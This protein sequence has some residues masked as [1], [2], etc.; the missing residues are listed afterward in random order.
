MNTVERI[1]LH[2]RRPTTDRLFKL[3]PATKPPLLMSPD[4]IDTSTGLSYGALQHDWVLANETAR[5]L[6]AIFQ[7]ETDNYAAGAAI[8]Q[9]ASATNGGLVGAL[10]I[11]LGLNR[12]IFPS[13][14]SQALNICAGIASAL[15]FLPRTPTDVELVE[16]KAWAAA[17]K[18]GLA[19]GPDPF[20]IKQHSMQREQFSSLIRTIEDVQ[21]FR[22]RGVLLQGD[23]PIIDRDRRELEDRLE[24]LSVPPEVRAL[25]ND[26]DNDA[27]TGDFKG[28]MEKCRTFLERT[29]EA[30]C[31]RHKPPEETPPLPEANAGGSIAPW[32][33][34]ATKAQLL[35]QK[36]HDVVQAVSSFLAIEGSHSPQSERRQFA[37]G[38]ACVIE[39]CLLV[40]DR[41]R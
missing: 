30:C 28:A 20:V 23:S 3:A 10:I 19:T 4:Q 24:R 21:R 37:V 32:L 18:T 40:A 6:I 31:R 1:F 7:T 2:L 8:V 33:K 9:G 13:A 5:A 36:E 26:A 16:L 41:V 38:K 14:T 12:H 11:A 25:L 27:D 17:Q 22:D 34:W 35:K 29:Y 15:K 39:W